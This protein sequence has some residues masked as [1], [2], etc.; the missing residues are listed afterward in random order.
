MHIQ[1]QQ[2]T[3]S[4]FTKLTRWILSFMQLYVNQILPHTLN[5]WN[6]LQAFRPENFVVR[7][8]TLKILSDYFNFVNPLQNRIVYSLYIRMSTARVIL[9]PSQNC[10]KLPFIVII[11][12]TFII[13]MYEKDMANVIIQISR[14]WWIIISCSFH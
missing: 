3:Y 6:I 11:H 8:W 10:Y 7:F 1:T 5:D 2:V 12:L 9:S 4:I 13:Q 14:Y